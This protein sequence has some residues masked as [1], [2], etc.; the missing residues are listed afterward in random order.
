[1]DIEVFRRKVSEIMNSYNNS[2]PELKLS[3]DFGLKNKDSNRKR[4]LFCDF[5]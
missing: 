5:R 4:R 2:K 3:G 1:M